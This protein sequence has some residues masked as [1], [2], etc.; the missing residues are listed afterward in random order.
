MK[1]KVPFKAPRDLTSATIFSSLSRD[2]VNGKE[3]NEREKRQQQHPVL[4]LTLNYYQEATNLVIRITI[5]T[6]LGP[7]V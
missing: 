5:I 7:N 6:K 4:Y 3:N 2:L 1:L